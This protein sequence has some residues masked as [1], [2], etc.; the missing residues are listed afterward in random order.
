[1]KKLIIAFSILATSVDNPIFSQHEEKFIDKKNE[2]SFEENKGQMKDQHWKA[3]PDVLYYG[4]SEGMNFYI[5][6][7]GMSYQLSRVESW[8]EEDKDMLRASL[9]SD[10]K[11]RQVPDQ[12][13]TYRVDAEWLNANKDFTINRGNALE[14]YNNYYN[15]PEGVEPALF[16]K[17][18]ETLT[19]LNVWNGVD[20]HYYGNGGFLETD[21]IVAPGADY[22]QIQ[23]DIKGAE[24]STDNQGNLILK[25]P[26]GEI[27]EGQLKV[28]QNDLLIAASWKIEGNRVSFDIPNYNADLALRIDPL[29]RV[30]GTYYGGATWGFGEDL[31]TDSLNNVYMTGYSN[32]NIGI[33]TQGSHQSSINGDEDAYLVKMDYLGSRLWGTYYGG[34]R[35]DCSHGIGLDTFGN[36]FITGYS[37]SSNNISTTSAH[38]NS[39]ADTIGGD[40]FL[41][42]FN[43]QGIRIWG[44]YLGGS[45]TDCAYDL[46][47]DVSNQIIIVGAS[48]SNNGISTINSHQ[49]FPG[50]GSTYLSG[51]VSKFT[52]N[53]NLIWSSY[54][55]G[56]GCGTDINSVCTDQ[57]KNIY[58]V[59][60]GFGNS[61]I[62]TI[63]SHQYLSGG[64]EE[65]FIVKFNQ[66]GTRIWGTFLGG[67]GSDRAYGICL[68]STESLYIT[69]STTSNNNI[70]TTGAFQTNSVS[71]DIFLAKFNTNGNRI[72]STYAGGANSQ[73]YGTSVKCDYNNNIYITGATNS[74]TNIATNGSYQQNYAGG[75][76]DCFLIKFNSNGTRTWGT[77]YGGQTWDYASNLAID[78]SNSI[79]LC[80]SSDSNSGIAT[81][82]SYQANYI[83]TQDDCNS[84]LVKFNECITVPNITPSGPTIFCQGD[85]IVLF[86]SSP[87]A[88][89]W[90]N[91]TT[92]QSITIYQSGNYFVTVSNGACTNTSNSISVTVLNSDFILSEPFNQLEYINDTAYFSIVTLNQSFNYQWQS[93]IGFGFTNLSNTGQYNGVTTNTLMVKNLNLTND[94]QNFRCVIN[95]GLCNDTSSI[96]ILS[97]INNLGITPI[98]PYKILH[99]YPNPSNSFIV[100]EIVENELNSKYG[101]IDNQGREIINGNLLD[102]KTTI[103]ISNL[104]K[105]VYL[106]KVEGAYESAIV[107]KE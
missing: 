44:T 106:L 42:K 58:F 4:V 73:E 92:S 71:Q 20:I 55:G 74:N 65:A 30:W 48:N 24:L 49:N 107:V 47:I 27:R 98:K 11:K 51:F 62:P 63:G 77:Y 64:G 90:S 1:M 8:K 101:I 34:Q 72:W 26:F 104:S 96:A 9:G 94:Q 15:V 85:S 100:V 16:V 75:W 10:D 61:L 28:Y 67:T 46:A 52:T 36:L 29:T 89:I 14:G 80:G 105:G 60:K 18:Y 84:F 19:L 43:E 83:G 32:S 38:Q 99:I 69:G 103:P 12:I 13:G 97:V 39:L 76:D 56:E 88:N 25:T 35:Y 59:G 68:D 5:K 82:G 40:A 37:K 50:G 87:N 22:N 33:A 41:V 6:N 66:F 79:Y 7:S 2:L 31:E 21:Y 102:I 17:K 23:I 81:I 93:D 78:N 53:G 86:S 45:L 95:D 91:G 57:Y 54:Y 3:R 70:A